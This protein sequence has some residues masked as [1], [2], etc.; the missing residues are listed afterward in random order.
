[1]PN[2]VKERITACTD[3]DQ[4]R[5]WIRVAATAESIKDVFD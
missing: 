4:L 5:A 2:D 3:L 1:V